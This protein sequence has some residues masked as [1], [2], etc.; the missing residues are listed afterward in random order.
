M[1]DGRTLEDVP[2]RWHPGYSD[3]WV[4]WRIAELLDAP[5]EVLIQVIFGI[6]AAMEKRLA[7][8]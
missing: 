8:V 6:Q 7:N 2:I 5:D 1:I 3:A 4:A